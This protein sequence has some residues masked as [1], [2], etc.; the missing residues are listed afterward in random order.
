MLSWQPACNVSYEHDTAK[1]MIQFRYCT[2]TTYD[3]VSNLFYNIISPCFDN[4][5]DWLVS[6]TIAT[7]LMAHLCE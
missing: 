6:V 4:G 2:S 3:I 7:I 5:C 1:I